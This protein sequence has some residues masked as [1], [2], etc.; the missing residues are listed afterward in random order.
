MDRFGVYSPALKALSKTPEFPT[1]QIV[2]TKD[3]TKTYEWLGA[4]IRT[5]NGLGDRSAFGLPD[6]KGIIVLTVEP[7]SLAAK[8]GL[9]PNDVIRTM[10]EETVYTIEAV[11]ALTEE[12][13]WK[14]HL[15]LLIFRN[16]TE[17]QKEIRFK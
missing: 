14:G 1:V 10:A 9:Q 2:D 5:V 15:S 17:E 8:A 4:T 3:E 13:R 7:G 16:Q 11:F 6:E 12:N